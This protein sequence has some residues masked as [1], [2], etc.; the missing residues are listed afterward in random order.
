MEMAHSPQN[1]VTEVDGCHPSLIRPS[2]SAVVFE[3]AAAEA[4]VAAEGY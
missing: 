3:L 4:F 1:W 2:A